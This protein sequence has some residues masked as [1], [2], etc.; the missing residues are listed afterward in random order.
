VAAGE[1]VLYSTSI[2]GAL[3]AAAAL[4]RQWRA[5]RNKP[6]VDVANEDHLRQTIKQMA[7]ETN[8]SRDYR[9]WQ[10][11]GYIDLDRRWHREMIVLLEDLVDQL[12]TELA[13]NGR[14]LHDI[15]VPPPPEIPEPPHGK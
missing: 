8:R 15:T 7:D 3:V 9:I 2:A 4:L 10:L 6:A 1:I 11:E 14:T 13:K 5:E 12:R